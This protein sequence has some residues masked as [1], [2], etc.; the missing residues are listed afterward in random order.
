MLAPFVVCP[1]VGAR[2]VL[3]RF[4]CSAFTGDRKGRPYESLVFFPPAVGAEF[5]LDVARAAVGASPGEAGLLCTA[6][7]AEPA[8]DA[9]CAAGGAIPGIRGGRG[10]RLRLLRAAVRAEA[11]LDILGAA[12]GAIP[13][14][15]GSRSGRGRRRHIRHLEALHQIADLGSDG[16]GRG[17]AD[18]ETQQI[19]HEAASAASGRDGRAHVADGLGIR[20][21]HLGLDDVLLIVALGLH[22]FRLGK[23][24]HALRLGFGLSGNDLSLGL[25]AGDFGLGGL[26]LQHGP[27]AGG[28]DGGLTLLLRRAVLRLALGL[29]R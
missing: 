6:F 23:P 19:T 2:L 8:R 15:G 28:L 12:V 7:G 20:L 5:A 16:A 27:A 9:L 11:A 29:G 24:G 13:A 14:Q 26:L 25:A 4:R 18:A 17:H 3:A 10:D 1:V 22:D 21:L